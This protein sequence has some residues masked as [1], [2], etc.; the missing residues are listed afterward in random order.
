MV[1]QMRRAGFTIDVR[2]LRGRGAQ[3]TIDTGGALRDHRLRLFDR[4]AVAI[5]PWDVAIDPWDVAIDPWDVAID[6]WDH[7][8]LC[9]LF[10]GTALRAGHGTASDELR[11]FGHGVGKP[12][13]EFSLFGMTLCLRPLSAGARVLRDLLRR[14]RI[15]TLWTQTTGAAFV[16]VVD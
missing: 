16:M 5:D 15:I 13:R 6:P 2:P 14:S 12:A 3:R 4:C 8:G 7:V 9:P 1:E 11:L 10:D